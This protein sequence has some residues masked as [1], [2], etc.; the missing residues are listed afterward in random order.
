MAQ[1]LS[2]QHMLIYKL[3]FLVTRNPNNM[4]EA[5]HIEPIEEI[6][7]ASPEGWWCN[8]CR[9]R[10]KDFYNSA[11][12]TG[13]KRCRQCHKTGLKRRNAQK[14]KLDWLTRKLQY[15]FKYQRRP[16]LAKAVTSKHVLQ[17]LMNQGI[18]YDDQLEMVK[19]IS[20]SFDPLLQN[21][22]FRVVFKTPAR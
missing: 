3:C 22:D 4:G 21:W 10:S 12:R 20:P 9:R 11:V 5:V 16:E 8:T 14:T 18:E 1:V 17:I 15:N 7:F 19:T 2:V 13:Y 6:P